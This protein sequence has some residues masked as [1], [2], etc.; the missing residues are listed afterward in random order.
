MRSILPQIASKVLSSGI[1]SPRIEQADLDRDIAAIKAKI[2][3]SAFEAAYHSGREM[4][5]D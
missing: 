3:P 2:G 4:T 1:F 5:L